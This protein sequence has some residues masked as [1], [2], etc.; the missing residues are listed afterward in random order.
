MIVCR[1]PARNGRGTG[2]GRP[3]TPVQLIAWR[4]L[5]QF[6]WNQPLGRQF[7]RVAQRKYGLLRVEQRRVQHGVQPQHA[8]GG[9]PDD[10]G[11]APPVA[12]S[13]DVV[14]QG[15]FAGAQE[16]DRTVTDS[17]PLPGEDIRLMIIIFI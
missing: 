17:E 6:A 11:D 13:Q 4:E 2:L 5:T 3:R 10:H 15:G 12:V 9:G 8:A 14:E 1:D 7:V 16:A